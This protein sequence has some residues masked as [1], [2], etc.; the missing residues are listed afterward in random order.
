MADVP[1]A[2]VLRVEGEKVEQ[3]WYAED[4][5]LRRDLSKL[6]SKLIS[7]GLSPQNL[8][9]LGPRRL[10]KS[11]VSDGLVNS[12][13]QLVE[14]DGRSSEKSAITYS[15]ISGFKGLE[16]DVVIVIEAGDLLREHSK[17]SLYVAT[18]RPRAMLAVF[19]PESAKDEYSEL[20]SR[21]GDR[22]RHESRG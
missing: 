13:Y 8:V 16:A 1:L 9:V 2:P 20:A 7:G 18:S 11:A 14:I 12:P 21:F 3:V 10:E 22:L 5:Q 4:A 17:S 15:T 19:S 6:I